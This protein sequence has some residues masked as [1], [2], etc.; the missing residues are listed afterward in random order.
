M[1][2]RGREQRSRDCAIQLQDDELLLGSSIKASWPQGEP[3]QWGE[4]FRAVC[5]YVMACF[6]ILSPGVSLDLSHAAALG[7]LPASSLSLVYAKLL[8]F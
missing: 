1:H 3:A 8:V 5:L 4:I 6:H 7:Q 2:V